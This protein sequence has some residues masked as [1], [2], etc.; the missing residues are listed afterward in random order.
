MSTL[1]SLLFVM[2]TAL[3]GWPIYN[4]SNPIVVLVC[5]LIG[6]M[7]WILA[8]WMGLFTTFYHR[9]SANEAFV[10]TGRGG[11]MV[12]LDSGA[13]VI[14]LLHRKIPVS[15][16]TMKLSV[17]LTGR[18]HALI[19]KD[20]LRVN[21]NAEFYIKVKPDA[22]GILQAARSLGD[23]SVDAQT[24]EDLVREKLVSALRH[25]AA[26]MELFEIHARRDEFAQ[27][28]QEHVRRDLSP[29]GI[30]L[31]SVTISSLDQLD[32]NQLSQV[33][34]FD[35]Q[36]RRKATEITT[37]QNVETTRLEREAE[38]AIAEKNVQTRQQILELQRQQA[39]AEAQHV[40]EVAK[41][42]AARQREEKE[43]SIEQ[44]RAVK[45]AQI[46]QDLAVQKRAVEKDQAL[47]ATEQ[48]KEQVR[49]GKEQAVQTADVTRTQT[50][51]VAEREREIVVA[52]KEAGRARA[53]AEALAAQAERERAHQQVMTVQ[54]LAA[55]EREAGVKLVAAKQLVEQDKI[56]RQTDVEVAS[57]A[58]IKQAEAEVE[59]AAKQAQARLLLAEAEMKAKELE[60]QAQE[61]LEMVSINVARE[62]MKVKEMEVELERQA[63]ENRQTF[64]RAAIEF[65]KAKLQIE[66]M[67]EAQIAMAQ[68]VGQALSH[69]DF[70]VYGDPATMGN[71]I[72]NLGKG[73]G[74]GTLAE[75]LMLGAP[76]GV[77]QLVSQVGE[78]VTAVA[79]D[80]IYPYVKSHQIF[81]CPSET[82]SPTPMPNPAPDQAGYTDY[83][84]NRRICGVDLERL[85]APAVTLMLGD[86][87]DGSDLTNARYSQSWLPSDWLQDKSKPCWRHLEG[88]NYGFA[89]GHVK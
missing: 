4:H 49:I 80:A 58:R 62:Q 44:E 82:A 2:G 9:T 53:E 70:K 74:L 18:D 19:T 76:D 52:E 12:V 89:D 13:Y 55:A 46:A 33:N 22:E 39:E 83:W 47:I 40:A 5:T 87:N 37:A 41:V 8:T 81:Q 3:I 59:A 15:L 61:A 69:A 21:V 50:V 23:K 34:V 88:A 60:A 78:V 11:A 48:Q 32:P 14:P 73:L 57:L 79:A 77:K 84:I 66:A 6:V 26:Q 42:R 28:V 75:G 36:G 54:A 35:V 38:R 27:I 68:A 86:G 43:F 31:E 10:R 56:K 24:V 65:E 63:L 45:E 20:N 72:S 67:K 85:K 71:M 25:A 51:E 29:N 64:E 1:I 16:E 17:A 7:C 30:D